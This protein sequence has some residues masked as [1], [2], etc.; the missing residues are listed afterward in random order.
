MRLVDSDHQMTRH[1]IRQHWPSFSRVEQMARI[2][3]AVRE[4]MDANGRSD[5]RAFHRAFEVITERFLLTFTDPKWSD[6]NV[7][8][9]GLKEP[10]IVCAVVCDAIVGG[11]TYGT[12]LDSLDR[13]FM[14]FALAARR[15]R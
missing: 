3:D 11:N 1:E 9:G 10:G 14:Q 8:P 12:D 4:A 2:G 6:R 15:G 13:Y 7:S 5:G